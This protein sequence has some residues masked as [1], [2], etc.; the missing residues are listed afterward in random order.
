MEEAS[1]RLD[2]ATTQLR[3]TTVELGQAKGQ[4]EETNRKLAAFEKVFGR[5]PGMAPGKEE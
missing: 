4:L 2:V 3:Q 1:Q 5:F